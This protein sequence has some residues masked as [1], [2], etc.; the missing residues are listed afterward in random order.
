MSA[1]W[2]D[3]ECAAYT[4]DLELWRAL[5]GVSP[6][7]ILDVGCGTGRIALDLAA[8]GHDLTGIDT[9]AELIDALRERADERRP[10][11]RRSWATR[12]RSISTK[13]LRW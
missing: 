6:G 9:D 10:P 1:V 11:W 8:R 4:A 3:V 12:A 7:S 5:A 13:R 2:H